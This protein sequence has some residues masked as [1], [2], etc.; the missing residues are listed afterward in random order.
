VLARLRLDGGAASAT[1]GGR[2]YTGV[3]GGTMLTMPGWAS[4]P[5]RY[6]IDAPAGVSAISVTSR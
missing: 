3:A 2:S 1:I 4:A 6:D 5:S